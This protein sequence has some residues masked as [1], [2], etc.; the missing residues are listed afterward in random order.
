MEKKVNKTVSHF[1]LAKSLANR[2]DI[3]GQTNGPSS[4]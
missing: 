1:T 4:P 3:L 2:N